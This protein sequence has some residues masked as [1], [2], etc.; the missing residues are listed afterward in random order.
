MREKLYIL[1][2]DLVEDDSDP[3][4]IRPA[5][6]KPFRQ[7]RMGRERGAKTD[8]RIVQN[9]GPESPLKGSNGQEAKHSEAAVQIPRVR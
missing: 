4:S 1:R 3:A 9:F 7:Y 5:T 8:L 6:G 2:R